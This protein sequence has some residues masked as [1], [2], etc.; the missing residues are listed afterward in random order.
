MTSV[1]PSLVRHPVAVPLGVALLAVALLGGV[2]S[3]AVHEENNTVQ[4]AAQGRVRSNRDAAVRALMR[5]TDDFK[6]TVATLS[7]IH[8]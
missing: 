7:L 2:A 6:L 8:I 4:S 3:V 1:V 5:Q